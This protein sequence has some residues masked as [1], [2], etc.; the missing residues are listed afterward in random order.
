VLYVVG[1]RGLHEPA[2]LRQRNGREAFLLRKGKLGDTR[3]WAHGRGMSH[4][5][6]W[7]CTRLETVADPACAPFLCPLHIQCIRRRHYN[8]LLPGG[9]DGGW[10][11]IALL[12]GWGGHPPPPRPPRGS[13]CCRDARARCGLC[14]PTDPPSPFPVAL[15]AGVSL[16]SAL[17]VPQRSNPR[18]VSC[19]KTAPGNLLR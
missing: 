5:S 11:D 10:Q 12:D 19:L 14:C 9:Q 4:R 13:W 17:R 8:L 2:P 6:Y 3:G 18:T 1:R 7:Y 15:P 16:E